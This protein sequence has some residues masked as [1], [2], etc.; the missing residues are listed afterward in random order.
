MIGILIWYHVSIS[1][2]V[3]LSERVADI[4][5]RAHAMKC[6]TTFSEAV[7]P[8]FIFERVSMVALWGIYPIIIGGIYLVLMIYDHGLQGMLFFFLGK[9]VYDKFMEGAI[10]CFI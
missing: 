9:V 10:T 4:K 5:T 6:L 3:G 7:G 2:F 1:I 8:G